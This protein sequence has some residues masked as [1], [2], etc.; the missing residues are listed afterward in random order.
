MCILVTKVLALFGRLGIASGRDAFSP[1][2]RFAVDHANRGQPG[3]WCQAVTGLGPYRAPSS[4]KGAKRPPSDLVYK[5]RDPERYIAS[6]RAVAQVAIAGG[7]VASVVYVAGFQSISAAV[8]TV[9]MAWAVVRWRRAPDIA[10]VVLHVENGVLDVR[11][12]PSQMLLCAPIGEIANVELDTKTIRRVQ[13]GSSLTAAARFID[14]KVG[15]EIDVARIVFDVDGVAE[16]VRLGEA[17]VAHMDCIEW[18]G[19]IRSFL[20]S[21]GWVPEDERDQGYAASD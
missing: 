16:P 11:R 2:V 20:R 21:H 8:F 3:A 6:T 10:E 17:Y 18:L 14:S 13:E 12:H 5:I 4:S 19:K 15:P 9:S 1:R 7:I